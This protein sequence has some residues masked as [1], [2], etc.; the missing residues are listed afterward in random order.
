M[1]QR[2]NDLIVGPWS[3]EPLVWDTLFVDGEEWPGIAAVRVKRGNKVERKP[4][5]GA[6]GETQTFGGV[7]NAD[8][9]ILIRFASSDEFVRLRDDFMPKLEPEPGKKDLAPHDISHPVADFR[10]VKSFI[11]LDVDG[12]FPAD[13]GQWQITI[14]AAE[15]RKPAP[16]PPGNANGSGDPLCKVLKQQQAYW[17]SQLAVVPPEKLLEVNNQII[18]L[19]AQMANHGCFGGVKIPLSPPGPTPG[20]GLV[21]DDGEGWFSETATGAED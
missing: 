19:N 9:Q 5:K 12:P 6:V 14:D 21:G 7:N 18:T 8:V 17:T 10:K 16:K 20:E 3:D 2:L 15:F 4:E 13:E 11:V 1:P